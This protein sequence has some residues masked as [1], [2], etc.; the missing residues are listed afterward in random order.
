MDKLICRYAI[1]P[2][3]AL[4]C[5]L[6]GF[7]LVEAAEEGWWYRA[8]LPSGGRIVAYHT[9]ADLPTARRTGSAAGFAAELALTKK[10]GT[11]V[12]IPCDAMIGRASARSQA[13]SDTGGADWCVIGDS[14]C[15][16]DPLSS[17]GIFNALYTGV[18]GGEA[19][20]AVLNGDARDLDD[21]RARMRVVTAAYRSDLCRYYALEARYT[22][23]L[24]WQR[25]ILAVT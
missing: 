21:Y 16:F 12:V 4:P 19:V 11:G 18:R 23:K 2:D 13:V 3:S 9:D 25:R 8:T 5:D 17:Q 14:A 7:S 20:G 15:A 6:A 22:E 24:F 10:V 1:V